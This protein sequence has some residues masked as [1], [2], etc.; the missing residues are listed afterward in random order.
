MAMEAPDLSVWFPK[1]KKF[2][3]NWRVSVV[4]RKV[5]P[6]LITNYRSSIR[7]SLDCSGDSYTDGDS[8]NLSLSHNFFDDRYSEKE[9]MLVMRALEGHECQH[10]NSTPIH[11]MK[12]IREWYGEYMA[13][14]FGIHKEIGAKIGGTFLNIF[15]DGRIE[16]IA[17]THHPGLKVPL[18]F[19][20]V[21]M[22]RD[23]TLSKADLDG[24]RLEYLALQ[25]LTLCYSKLGVGIKGYNTLSGTEFDKQFQSIYPFLDLAVNGLTCADCFNA[26]KDALTILAPYIAKLVKADSDLMKMLEK[27]VDHMSGGTGNESEVNDGDPA[28]GIR[29]G[30]KPGNKGKA[31]KGKTDKDK[32]S[33]GETSQDSKD[34]KDGEGGEGK[35]PRE[36]AEAGSST[37]VSKESSP[38]GRCMDEES[39][40][41]PSPATDGDDDEEP[42]P[43]LDATSLPYSEQELADAIEKSA[44]GVAPTASPKSKEPERNE[45]TRKEKRELETLYEG[46]DYAFFKEE[47]AMSDPAPLPGDTMAKA[48]ILHRK[49]ARILQQRRQE[50]RNQRKGILDVRSLWKTGCGEKS[51]MMKRGKPIT[52][53]CAV[54][55]LVDNSGSMAGQKFKLARLTA[56]ALEIALHG[57]ASLKIS[58]FCTKSTTRHDT[59]KDFDAVGPANRSIAFGSITNASITAGGGNKDGYSIRVA[60]RELL[61]RSEKNKVLVIISDGEPTDYRGGT[62]QGREDVRKAVAEA[63]KKGIVVIA[64]LI[65]DRSYI[66]RFKGRHVEMY[67]K[68]LIACEPTSMLAE[69]EK[70]FTRLIKTA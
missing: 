48:R 68:N 15:E 13:K 16:Q 46:D 44:S 4:L 61:K 57:L 64:L 45:L 2:L 20:N 18:Q 50:Q 10:I 7:L 38:S 66:D 59:I 54:F 24:G 1:Y 14:K 23:A 69:F 29:I 25:N 36:A 67:G 43:E 32:A 12:D 6:T 63:K 47:F 53:D 39:T 11:Y 42:I 33:K 56:G 27:L 49:L 65:G 34:G 70:L 62:V 17:A 28:E 19:M 40:S 21:E 37:S 9:W 41:G 5:M 52:A 30:S 60:T 8:I 35:A 58:L 22:F 3:Q 55:E 26:T 51:I 31:D